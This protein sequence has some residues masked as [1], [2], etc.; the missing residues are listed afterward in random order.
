VD[1]GWQELGF[2]SP[3]T[4]R[5]YHDRHDSYGFRFIGTTVRWAE[6]RMSNFNLSEGKHS[7]RI[8]SEIPIKLRY[9][10]FYTTIKGYWE[11]EHKR[12]NHISDYEFEFELN[13]SRIL[14]NSSGWQYAIYM[15]TNNGFEF[16]EN[17][18]TGSGA[19]FNA[20]QPQVGTNV[21]RVVSTQ[22]NYTYQNGT[23]YFGISTSYFEFEKTHEDYE[24]DYNF[25]LS[26]NNDFMFWRGDVWGGSYNVSIDRHDGQGFRWLFQRSANSNIALVTLGLI[27]GY[28][29]LRV[30]STGDRYRIINGILTLGISTGFWEFDFTQGDVYH[31]DEVYIENNQFI[32]GRLFRDVGYRVY[33]D[34]HDGEGF[35]FEETIGRNMGIG[36]GAFNPSEG[37]NTVR[38]VSAPIWQYT[39]GILSS[40]SSYGYWEFEYILLDDVEIGETI[41]ILS[42]SELIWGGDRTW[43]GIWINRAYIG[44][45]EYGFEV[46]IDDGRAWIILNEIDL[47]E[48]RDYI[49]KVYS[50]R[51]WNYEDGVISRHRYYQYF[52]FEFKNQDFINEDAEFS[53]LDN[54]R[55]YWGTRARFFY[56]TYIDRHDGEGFEFVGEFGY[57]SWTMPVVSIPLSNL[58]LVGGEYA[59]RVS[60][61]NNLW[62]FYDGVIFKGA[63]IAY[64]NFEVENNYTV[65]DRTFELNVWGDEI[66]WRDWNDRNRQEAVYID[67][68]DDK[69][70]VFVRDTWTQQR[71]AL[72]LLNP[73]LGQNTVMVR[74]ANP[75]ATYS[76]GTISFSEIRLLWNFEFT[77]NNFDTDYTFN[78]WHNSFGFN[79][80][81]FVYYNIYV[82]RHDESDFVLVY[83]NM[84]WVGTT[85]SVLALTKG[86]NTV[87]VV[88]TAIF[89]YQN[90]VLNSGFSIGYWEVK[91]LYENFTTPHNF[92]TFANR[93]SIGRTHT[94]ASISAY[95]NR[96]DDLGYVFFRS[97]NTQW[98]DFLIEDA[99]FN[100]GKNGIRVQANQKSFSYQD[101]I[102]RWGY[103]IYYYEFEYIVE[104]SVIKDYTF[105]FT[106]IRGAS[107][108]T[109]AIMGAL[110]FDGLNI[111]YQIYVDRHDGQGFVFAFMHSDISSAEQA[112]VIHFLGLTQGK[113]TIRLRAK[114]V[115]SFDDD[116]LTVRTRTAFFELDYRVGNHTTNY[117]FRV[118]NDGRFGWVNASRQYRVYIDRGTGFVHMTTTSGWGGT[119]IQNP[120]IGLNRIR[121]VSTQN[122]FSLREDG[123]LYFGISTGYWEFEFRQGNIIREYEFWMWAGQFNQ[124]SWQGNG[125]YRVY[126]N[127]QDGSGFNFVI[128]SWGSTG[129]GMTQLN[130]SMGANTL[131]IIS[132]NNIRRY[133]DGV[134]YEGRSVGYF[135]FEARHQ[136]RLEVEDEFDVCFGNRIGWSGQGRRVY[137]DRHDGEGFEFILTASSSWVNLSALGLVDGEYTLRVDTIRIWSIVGNALIYAIKSAYF[138]FEFEIEDIKLNYEFGLVDIGVYFYDTLGLEIALLALMFEPS[139]YLY[140]IYVD[141]HD[142]EGFVPFWYYN[143][144][145]YDE[146]LMGTLWIGYFITEG[147]NSVKFVSR[148]I[149]FAYGVIRVFERTA[150]WEVYFESIIKKSD[151]T[152]NIID[153]NLVLGTEGQTNSIYAFILD[154]VIINVV[155]N[156]PRILLNNISS[157][158]FYGELEI[159]IERVVSFEY[160]N[161]VLIL[162]S[163]ERRFILYRH[164]DGFIEILPN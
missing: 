84:R 66:E 55:I 33:I 37:L 87:R 148:G 28:Y 13:N 51:F 155:T 82:D 85:M 99:N 161:G 67:R 152:L 53:L 104:D 23:L 92:N 79:S 116:I 140:Y 77:Q 46:L 71:I 131:R 2:T 96:H 101:G 26:N 42:G 149:E 56:K 24:A 44:C 69:G 7:V 118:G 117:N 16:R 88:S 45:N 9:N 32:F 151:T 142:G 111:A 150:I 40:G 127:R 144:I 109:G 36:V 41:T 114:E 4:F 145:Y 158:N 81:P 31:P 107:T 129:V 30:V 5:I 57:G 110:V 146:I 64:W 74:C 100:V 126:I 76:D 143:D 89:S 162:T 113:N 90:G 73:S 62:S 6:F 48:D 102:L 19:R 17:V 86:F 50:G 49:I 14:W 58:N 122:I 156:F 103:N 115:L 135:E 153:N 120:S 105:I 139:Q 10:D 78:A 75:S 97:S 121:V 154:G 21:M 59:I 43:E 123:V 130:P 54:N 70:L 47:S 11:F 93:F 164:S 65:I 80:H 157:L 137:L 124:L 35:V 52:E 91:L 68:H 29:A 22:N 163:I 141:R 38:L 27:D 119:N 63:R 34:R 112:I 25:T 72:N 8:V 159:R 15:Q 128:S 94:G 132:Q 98:L 39:D 160:D 147:Q 106:D 12:Q 61:T 125:E 108:P 133:I 1:W 3:F 18:F 83:S 136:D 60:T 95:I 20:V 134:I 138:E